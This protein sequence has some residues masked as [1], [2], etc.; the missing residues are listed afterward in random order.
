M[1]R[2]QF[3]PLDTSAAWQTA[4]PTLVESYMWQEEAVGS[5]ADPTQASYIRTAL[6][7]QPSHQGLLPSFPLSPGPCCCLQR[8]PSFPFASPHTVACSGHHPK[9]AFPAFWVSLG[10]QGVCFGNFVSS[11]YLLVFACCS[12]IC[13]Q[14]VIFSHTPLPICLLLICGKGFVKTMGEGGN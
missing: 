5:R 8:P 12:F 4:A 11:D 7:L 13:W 2:G 6:Y 9:K 10:S 1:P 14:T 3:F